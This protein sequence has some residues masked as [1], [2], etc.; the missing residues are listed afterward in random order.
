MPLSPEL[1]AEIRLFLQ[2]EIRTARIPELTDHTLLNEADRLAIYSVE[3]GQTHSTAL[4]LLL[5]FMGGGGSGSGSSGSAAAKG[6][7]IF[8]AKP[9]QIA[10][11]G[12]GKTIHLPQFA[13][14]NYTLTA[15]S[16]DFLDNEYEVLQSGGFRITIPGYEIQPDTRFSLQFAEPI[17]ESPGGIENL[18]GGGFIIGKLPVTTNTQMLAADLGK[19]VQLRG[20]SNQITFTL[21]DL[22]AIPAY[23]VVIIE[24]CISNVREQRITG[25]NGQLI[26]M[27]NTSYQSLHIRAGEAV[28]LFADT[29]GWYVFNDFGSVYRQVGFVFDAYKVGGDAL[30]LEGQLVSKTEYARLW[31]WVEGLGDAKVPEAIWSSNKGKFADVNNDQFRLPDWRDMFTRA[32]AAG[33]GVGTFEDS[34]NKAHNHVEAPYNKAIAKAS[35]VPPGDQS[36]GNTDSNNNQFEYRV[37]GMNATMWT[38]AEIKSS[39]GDEA[40]PKNMRL[41]KAIKV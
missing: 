16:K 13:G 14:K 34:Q 32:A 7:Y 2:E 8:D 28:W 19:L 27:N 17:P 24:A 21:P 33:K 22:S 1:Q 3:S 39:G 41:I 30:A 12:D 36:P 38:Q 29:D 25:A 35:D 26:Y 11:G 31:Q 10:A 23:S 9:A 15:D 6:K 4:G 20:G 40:R 37:G 5:Q 18:P